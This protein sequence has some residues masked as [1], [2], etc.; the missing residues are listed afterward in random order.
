[1]TETSRQTDRQTETV[2]ETE[3]TKG[4]TNTDKGKKPRQ[5]NREGHTETYNVHRHS[6]NQPTNQP[7]PPPDKKTADNDGDGL[8]V[9]GVGQRSPHSCQLALEELVQS[10]LPAAPLRCQTELI[11][12]YAHN[13]QLRV[14]PLFFPLSLLLIC[15]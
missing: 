10:A 4:P 14:V 5:R 8:D 6:S 9:M 13:R 3:E 7:K 15:L 1:M 12:K 2:P 11:S